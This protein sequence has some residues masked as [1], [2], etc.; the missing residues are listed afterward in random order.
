MLKGTVEEYHVAPIL[1]N[2]LRSMA[3]FTGRTMENIIDLLAEDIPLV[4]PPIHLRS[5][6][7]L[8]TDHLVEE[9]EDEEL[10]ELVS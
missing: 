9:D 4:R 10:E 2:K 5:L 1:D 8:I 3:Q 7:E 6:D